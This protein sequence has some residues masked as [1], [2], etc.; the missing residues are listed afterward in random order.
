[1]EEELFPIFLNVN[2]QRDFFEGGS[3]K[4]RSAEHILTNLNDI[5]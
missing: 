5:T 1:M 3:Y 4:I 2:T